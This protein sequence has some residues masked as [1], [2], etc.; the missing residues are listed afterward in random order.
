GMFVEVGGADRN[1]KSVT[2]RWNMLAEGDAG[3][4]IPSMA[5]ETV[6]RAC[7]DGR[8]PAPGARAAGPEVDLADYERRF[9]ARGIVTGVTRGESD[10]TMPIYRQLLGDA[11]GR[12]GTPIQEAHDVT[13]QLVLRGHADVKRGRGLVSRIIGGIV[14]FP[15]DGKA[16]PVTVTL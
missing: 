1:G 12:L 10:L 7:L 9:A 13:T 2:R 11:Y 8:R 3:P 5:I 15:P 4:L 6:I 16:T 14:G